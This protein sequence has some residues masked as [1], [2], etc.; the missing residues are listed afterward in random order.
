MKNVLDKAG[1]T[2]FW[3][4]IKSY[5]SSLNF[6]GSS[7]PGGAADKAASI[8]YGEVDSTSTSTVFTATVPGITKLEDGVC[9]YLRNNIV[10][11]ATNFTLNIND[12]GAKPVYNNLADATRDTNIFNK[13]YT[14]FFIYNSARVS[15]GCWDCYRGYDSNTNT[16]GYQIRTAST[17]LPVTS[18]TGRYRL[19]FTSPDH[20]HWVPST[21]STAT[22]ANVQMD[23]NS[24]EPFDPFGPIAYYAYTTVLETGQ[25]PSVSYLYQQMSVT[26][27][28]LF[29]PNGGNISL[30]PYT[31]VY[32][33]CVPD[34]NVAYLDSTNPYTQTLPTT[35][36]GYI[37]IYLG[38]AYTVTSIEIRLEHPVYIYRAG[39]GL[40]L[41]SNQVQTSP[42]DI[43]LN[44]GLRIK[45]LQPE[46]G[47]ANDEYFPLEPFTYNYIPLENY[48]DLNNGSTD[49]QLRLTY[50]N[51]SQWRSTYNNNSINKDTYPSA[52]ECAAEI[53]TGDSYQTRVFVTNSEERD[54]TWASPEI[55]YLEPE[56]TYLLSIVNGTCVM[57]KLEERS[58]A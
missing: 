40:V 6:A 18:T 32:I 35:E 25:R 47:R 17:S 34:G 45:D 29:N 8:P 36:D 31:P 12:L 26:L 9:V 37:Y 28:Y 14:M 50:D 58:N 2:Y 44:S 4:K 54:L 10:T 57:S 51:A 33:K 7:T 39:Q 16:L 5:I 13:A 3:G 43:K 15:G 52:V 20:T 48:P 53:T 42:M 24:T 21:N 30:T 41:Y 19:L 55:G 11:S 38:V 1:L 56:S 27:G 46:V 22:A 49:Y 23:V